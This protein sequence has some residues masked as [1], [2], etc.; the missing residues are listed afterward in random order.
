MAGKPVRLEGAVKCWLE[1]RGFGFITVTNGEDVFV[2]RRQLPRGVSDL[3]EGERVRFD[4]HHTPRG[5]QAYNLEFPEEPEP[6]AP[7]VLD[8]GT[9]LDELRAAMNML[10]PE[11]EESVVSLAKSHGWVA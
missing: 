3:R 8:E 7:D 5:M 6:R 2:H 10:W 4:G 9:F 11:D 1:D